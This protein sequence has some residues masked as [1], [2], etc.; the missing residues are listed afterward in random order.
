MHPAPMPVS[1]EV[2]CFC[3][4]I[5]LFTIAVY[6]NAHHSIDAITTHDLI[7]HRTAVDFSCLYAVF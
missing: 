3:M 1:P 7:P 4:P 6:Y 5:T 2:A